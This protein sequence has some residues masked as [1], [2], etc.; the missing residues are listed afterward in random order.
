MYLQEYSFLYSFLQVNNKFTHTYALRRL[1]SL[2]EESK[3]HLSGLVKILIFRICV[4]KKI[5]SEAKCNIRFSRITQVSRTSFKIT[6][7]Y[8]ATDFNQDL[9]SKAKNSCT[10]G[11]RDLYV[12][13]NADIPYIILRKETTRQVYPVV[14]DGVPHDLL[15]GTERTPDQFLP[16]ENQLLPYSY[17]PALLPGTGMWESIPALFRCG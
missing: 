4:R 7:G 17:R 8:R 13:T 15:P 6:S 5:I 10:F 16:L 9:L 12:T 11:N 1:L 14:P 3:T 2:P